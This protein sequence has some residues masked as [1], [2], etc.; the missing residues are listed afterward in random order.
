[1]FNGKS[2]QM[3]VGHR[4]GDSLAIREHLL[5]NSSADLM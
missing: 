5:E 3:C 2:S 4:I 1:M